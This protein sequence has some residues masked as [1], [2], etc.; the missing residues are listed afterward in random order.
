MTGFLFSKVVRHIKLLK[1]KRFL[2]L[3]IAVFGIALILIAVITF[4]GNNVGNFVMSI[5]PDLKD[6]SISMSSTKEFI[7]PT[8]LL[9]A[10]SVH[11][12]RDITYTM[13][14]IEEVKKT[15]GSY[16]D[17]YFKYVA[18]TFYVK[19]FGNESTDLT[20]YLQITS[21][22]KNV[23]KAIRVMIISE[24]DGVSKERVYMAKDKVEAIYEDMPDCL[25][26]YNEKIVMQDNI[27]GF[28]PEQ[29]LKF[30]VVMWIE[31]QD[32]D[33]TSDILGGQIKIQMKFSAIN[34][35]DEV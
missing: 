2:E 32:P 24:V 14:N 13:L 12:A 30:S 28:F 9:Q 35:G 7:N 19:N 5:D 18:Y 33:T 23:D 11:N 17:P 8:S 15:D 29:V 4:Y 31:G 6:K 21:A 20:Y 26:F 1:N 10:D 27:Y 22:K 34:S 16:N 25:E 3:G